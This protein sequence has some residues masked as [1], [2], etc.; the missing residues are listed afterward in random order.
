MAAR[1]GTQKSRV[2]HLD[3]VDRVQRVGDGLGM[4]GIS[5]RTLGNRPDRDPRPSAGAPVRTFRPSPLQRGDDQMRPTRVVDRSPTNSVQRRFR[6][7]RDQ[8]PGAVGGARPGQDRDGSPGGRVG[9]SPGRTEREVDPAITVN[10]VRLQTNVVSLGPTTQDVALLPR[11]VLVPDDRV[12]RHGDD[13]ELAIAVDVGGDHG[14]TNLAD[15]RVDHFPPP[16]RRVRRRSHADERKTDPQ[17][18]KRQNV[19]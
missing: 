12:V 1:A 10:I 8:A 3:I 18:S 14:I 17:D 4:P 13:V 2:D 16:R 19:A 15:R 9:R 7:D 5:K 11:G 6:P